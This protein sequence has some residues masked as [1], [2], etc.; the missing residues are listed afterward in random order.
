[1]TQL[2][3]PPPP[4]VRLDDGSPAPPPGRG[5]RSAAC[6][7]TLRRCQC[8]LRYFRRRLLAMRAV[9]P[10]GSCVGLFSEQRRAGAQGGAG[11]YVRSVGACAA[12]SRGIVRRRP[13]P[14]QGDGLKPA[15]HS[16]KILRSSA[17]SDVCRRPL[18]PPALPQPLSCRPPRTAG[19]TS[20]PRHTTLRPAFIHSS[21][22]LLPPPQQRFS[23]SDPP[24]P[25]FPTAPLR[26]RLPFPR[27]PSPHLPPLRLR[28][29]PP[30]RSPAATTHPPVPVP[31]PPAPVD[32]Q[33]PPAAG[34]AA[35]S[36]QK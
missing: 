10:I 9:F 1:M 11:G 33:Q 7:A 28:R 19:P 12:A 4:K 26:H 14:R 24:P 34:R 35:P 27:P 8:A 17:S 13:G 25:S 32:R 16:N 20:P 21:L 3:P 22:P 30:R 6:P 31:T 15:A 29:L 36:P 23:A 18:G 2:S 5:A